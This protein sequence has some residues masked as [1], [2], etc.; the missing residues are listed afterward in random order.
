MHKEAFLKKHGVKLGFMS[1]FL[2]AASFALM[3][4]P[5]VNAGEFE[6]LNANDL[7]SAVSVGQHII[8][9]AITVAQIINYLLSS[10]VTGDSAPHQTLLLIC[11]LLKCTKFLFLCLLYKFVLLPVIA[12]PSEGALGH[13]YRIGVYDTVQ[14]SIR[15]REK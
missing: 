4:Q 6:L 14:Y 12:P 7:L 13:V 2:K 5:V 11:I 10:N 15:K 1:A 8:M 9:Q 3:D